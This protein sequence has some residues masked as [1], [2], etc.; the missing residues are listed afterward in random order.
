MNDS[1]VFNL[2]RRNIAAGVVDP[3]PA[4]KSS[5]KSE[6]KKLPHRAFV[7]TVYDRAFPK[8]QPPK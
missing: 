1:N 6:A 3:G 5:Y 2:D 8:W 4:S 7:G